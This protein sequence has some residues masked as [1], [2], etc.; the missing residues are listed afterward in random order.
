VS[1]SGLTFQ[2]SPKN[3]RTRGCSLIKR[4]P[5]L[6]LSLRAGNGREKAQKS[7]EPKLP[8][9]ETVLRN[10][11]YF[12]LSSFFGLHFSQTFFCLAA[13]WQH[14]CVHSLPAF[15]ASSQQLAETLSEPAKTAIAA[16]RV[17]ILMLFIASF[18]GGMTPVV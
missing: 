15:L 9:S 5:A 13:S 6:H 11:A 10:E 7:G 4:G 2:A 12:F 3:R 18:R 8:L 17:N 16:I 1:A 14:L